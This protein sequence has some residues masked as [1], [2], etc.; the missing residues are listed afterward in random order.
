MVFAANEENFNSLKKEMQETVVGLGYNKV[1]VVGMKNE[2]P[3]RYKSS[4]C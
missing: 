4:S 2:R 1:L 3:E